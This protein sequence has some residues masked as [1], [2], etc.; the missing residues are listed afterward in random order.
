MGLFDDIGGTL[1]AINPTMA[2]ANAAT[3][4]GTSIFNA[5]EQ[6]R[7]NDRMEANAWDMYQTQRGDEN[8]AVQRRAKDMEAAGINPLLAA[9][10]PAGT[11][12]GSSP[13]MTAPQIVAPDIMGMITTTEMLKNNEAD[14]A[15]KAAQTAKTANESVILGPDAT[16]SNWLQKKY[17]QIVDE[18]DQ[19]NNPDQKNMKFNSGKQ[20]T[21]P[22]V[23]IGPAR[24]YFKNKGKD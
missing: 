10:N 8:T 20:K 12:S 15:L 6:G 1:A 3:S 21:N 14:R 2:I 17:K 5:K 16:K 19:I 9:G 13:S 23:G 4:I 22:R 24:D 11:A 18:I 7:I